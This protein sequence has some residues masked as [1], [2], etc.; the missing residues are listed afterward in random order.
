MT[1]GPGSYDSLSQLKKMDKHSFH[2]PKNKDTP[3]NKEFHW[4][5]DPNQRASFIP[6]VQN[7]LLGPGSYDYFSSSMN[8]NKNDT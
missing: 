7:K 6:N 2:S 1:P 8:I 5:I 4:I 3:N